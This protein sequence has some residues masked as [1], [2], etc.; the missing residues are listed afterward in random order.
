MDK[1]EEI[2][3]DYHSHMEVRETI[4]AVRRLRGE[5]LRNVVIVHRSLGNFDKEKALQFFMED[6]QIEPIIAK[7]KDCIHIGKYDF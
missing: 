3:S 1:G 6:L 4:D 2:R 7:A 5:N